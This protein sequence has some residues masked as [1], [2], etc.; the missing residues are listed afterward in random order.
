MTETGQLKG[1]M[2]ATT[3]WGT[4][5]TRVA[6]PLS[7]R[8]RPAPRPRPARR[9][10]PSRPSWPCRR[11]PPGASCRARG[12]AGGRGRRPRRRPRRPPPR[13]RPRAARSSAASAAHAGLGPPG[14]GDGLVELGGRGR[15]GVE[16]DL[17]RPG[18]VRDRVG[19]LAARHD[20][21]VDEEA[22]AGRDVLDVC[23]HAHP[24]G[25]PTLLTIVSSSR[26]SRRDRAD[27]EAGRRCCPTPSRGRSWSP[28][29]R[30]TTTSSNRRIS[31]RAACPP[32]CQD[33][34]PRV[35]EQ[36]DGTQSWVFEGSHYPNV[37]LNAVVGRPQR[38]MEHGAGPLRRDAAR[39]LR[40]RGRAS[41]TWTGPASG[42]RLCFPSLVSGF[43]GAVY[44]RATTPSSAW[45]ACA[46]STTGTS[47]SGRA[48]IPSASS[49]CSCPWLAD[50][51]LAAR[52]GAGQRGAGL[53]GR[54][55][56]RV[57]GSARTALHL[58]RA[59]GP[60]LRRLR[61]D[62][63]RRLPAHRGVRLGPAALARPAL[64]AAAHRV[65]GQRA[66]GR[67]ANGCGRA[68]RCASRA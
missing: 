3:P 38:G 11:S 17:G 61:G 51:E 49:R 7:S 6:P 1:R 50:V 21:A 15:R 64:R 5:S 37:G 14:R 59:V 30:S 44:S 20:V 56:P 13:R 67:R 48:R 68:S 19:A 65:P 35:V 29:S 26:G 40:H 34:A 18:R 32:R 55:L 66:A 4:H 24:R 52:R 8:A 23:G 12:S 43:C 63:H 16:D 58:Q 36:D 47:R 22:D 46:P 45:P 57:P 39:L 2:A 27:A 25:R 41:P 60:V 31:S 9:P 33:G 53:Q 28:S 62:R 54:E 42:P 10:P